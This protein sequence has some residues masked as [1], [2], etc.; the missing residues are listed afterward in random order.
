M[1]LWT[2]NES[3][4]RHAHTQVYCNMATKAGLYNVNF[5]NYEITKLTLR[6]GLWKGSEII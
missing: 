6:H 1:L 2:G 3:V 5:R 4:R